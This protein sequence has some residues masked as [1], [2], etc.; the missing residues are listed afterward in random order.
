MNPKTIGRARP[1]PYARENRWW[2]DFSRLGGGRHPLKPDGET[3]GLVVLGPEHPADAQDQNRREALRL[4]DRDWRALEAT[5]ARRRDHIS[6]AQAGI[7][8][9][10]LAEFLAW[11]KDSDNVRVRV[12]AKELRSIERGCE[13]ILALKCASGWRHIS[14]FNSE[15]SIE[16][17]VKEL[18]AGETKHGGPPAAAT[19]RQWCMAFSGLLTYAKSKGHIDTNAWYQSLNIPSGSVRDAKG[20]RV[21]QHFLAPWEVQAVL[22]TADRAVKKGL[23]HRNPWLRDIVYVFAYTGARREEVLRLRLAHIDFENGVINVPG[24]K[25]RTSRRPVPLHP[26]LRARLLWYRKNRSPG[27]LLFPSIAKRGVTSPSSKRARATAD[28]QPMLGVAKGLK[29]LMLA[30]G[31]AREKFLS[32]SELR[33][34]GGAR[35]AAPTGGPQARAACHH[36]WRHTYAMTRLGMV[37]ETGRGKHA[38]Y[39][40]REVA[41]ELGHTNETEIRETYGFRTDR[42]AWPVLELDY[43]KAPKPPRVKSP[44]SRG[45]ASAS[46]SRSATAASAVRR[47]RASPGGAARREPSARG[48][49][50]RRAPARRA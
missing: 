21:P 37:K 9:P 17:I 35:R 33:Q 16:L 12:S 40:E 23:S 4:F 18:K 25:S 49:R 45:G 44:T 14:A 7:P 15:S 34:L 3:R 1:V 22:A 13:R 19:V 28:T 11:K 38:H 31:I 50:S 41:L 48:P 26:P 6:D 47:Q 43:R 29:S 39:S 24:T 5:N 2:G 30:A 8:K 20:E 36:I 46:R 32:P 10:L 27:D 42:I